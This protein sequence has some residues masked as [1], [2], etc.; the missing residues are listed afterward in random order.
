MSKLKPDITMFYHIQSEKYGEAY[1]AYEHGYYD[2]YIGDIYW[3]LKR[4]S[5]DV[6]IDD[7][8]EDVINDTKEVDQKAIQ[9][10]VAFWKERLADM[11]DREVHPDIIKFIE[12]AI[13]NA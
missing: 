13:S 7:V 11:A 12:Y 8:R 6:N 2:E 3:W 9:E 1:V 5:H 10:N 4:N